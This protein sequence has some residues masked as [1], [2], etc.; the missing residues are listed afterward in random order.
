M[1]IAADQHKNNREL[2]ELRCDRGAMIVQKL[3]LGIEAAVGVR[4]LDEHW[5]GGG[6]PAGLKGANIPIISRLMAIAQHLDAFCMD[7]GPQPAIDTL[8]ERSG[9]WFDPELTAAAVSLDQSRRLF[10][11][12][13]PYDPT[14][15][16][17]SDPSSQS[18]KRD[19]PFCVLDIDAILLETFAD[20][21]W[22]R[23]RRLPTGTPWA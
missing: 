4:H 16:I 1:K 17:E 7:Q 21:G 9:R 8:I 15:E 19:A 14:K 12:C 20:V 18:G 22:T 11:Y 5:D 2:I 23:N 13:L 10:Q 6:Y 3:G